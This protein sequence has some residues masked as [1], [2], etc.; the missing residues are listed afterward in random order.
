MLCSLTVITVQ[1]FIKIGRTVLEIYTEKKLKKYVT[2]Y[3]RCQNSNFPGILTHVV[4]L[5]ILWLNIVQSLKNFQ[6]AVSEKIE[7]EHFFCRVATLK[8][9]LFQKMKK[10]R[11]GYFRKTLIYQISTQSDLWFPRCTPDR[12]TD[13][14]ICHPKTTFSDSWSK[15]MSEKNKISRSKKYAITIL[16]LANYVGCEKVKTVR[17]SHFSA[18]FEIL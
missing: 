18:L 10:N 7:V 2:L 13:T 11:W 17:K 8:N 16:T 4:L 14:Q 9:Q 3:G 12:Q 1:I 15:V 6:C 5:V